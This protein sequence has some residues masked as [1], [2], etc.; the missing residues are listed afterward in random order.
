LDSQCEGK[1]LK[2]STCI[3]K[4]PCQTETSP[5]VFVSGPSWSISTVKKLKLLISYAMCIV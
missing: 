2:T 1:C 5:W 4:S 3:G